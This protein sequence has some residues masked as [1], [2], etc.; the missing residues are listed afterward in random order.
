MRH[1][2]QS[3]AVICVAVLLSATAQGQAQLAANARRLTV[4]DR[5]GQAIFTAVEEGLYSQP[6]FSHDGTKLAVLKTN[7]RQ[8]GAARHR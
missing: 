5:R 7:P 6:A 4:V 3:L 8:T 2:V 1:A